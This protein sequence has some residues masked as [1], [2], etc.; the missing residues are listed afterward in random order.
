MARKISCGI[1]IRFF[2]LYDKSPETPLE[3]PLVSPLSLYVLV[4]VQFE[5]LQNIPAQIQYLANGLH[6]SPKSSFSFS[7]GDARMGF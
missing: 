1:G 4:T 5:D 7:G 2:N 6:D 3:T